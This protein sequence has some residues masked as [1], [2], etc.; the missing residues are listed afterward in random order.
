MNLKK[1][2][3]YPQL[4]SSS[5]FI[6]K[7]AISSHFFNE[8]LINGEDLRLV[9]EILLEKQ[10]Y[11]LLNTTEY[12]YR[13][14]QDSSSFMDNRLSSK[15]AYTEKMELCFKHLIDYSIRKYSYVP[16]FIQYVIALD[17]NG[18]ISST[19]FEDVI[20]D[21]DELFEFWDCLNYIM[22]YI[23]EDVIKNHD[24]LTSEYKKFYMYLKNKKETSIN[25]SSKKRVFLKS[26]DFVIDR[27]HRDKLFLDIIEIKNGF[28]NISGYFSSKFNLDYVNIEAI[29][30]TPNKQ[31]KI[32]PCKKVQYPTTQSKIKKYLG[33]EWKYF[34]NFD[35]KIPIDEFENFKV[36]FRYIFKKE[37][38]EV[39]IKPKL[40]FRIYANLSLVSNYFVKDSKIV[41]FKDNALH[42]VD[43]SSKFRIKLELSSLL[44]IIKSNEENKFEGIFFRLLYYI[45]YNHY[46]S[47]RIWL[48]M[49]RPTSAED[50]ARALFEYAV[51]QDEDIEKYFIVDKKSK[52]YK[53]LKKLSKHVVKYRSIK[54]KLLY[55]FSEKIISSHVDA[56]WLN[57]YFD[58]NRRLFSGLSTIEACFLQHGVTKDDIS[59][60]IR[61]YFN[62]L[63]LF[64]TT[65]DYERDSIL[66]GNDATFMGSM[67]Y[68][69][70]SVN[71]TSNFTRFGGGEYSCDVVCYGDG[72]FNG[73]TVSGDFTVSGK[74]SFGGSR[75]YGNLTCEGDANLQWVTV[76]KQ[77]VLKGDSIRGT[78]NFNKIINY[79][80]L[81]LGN[82]SSDESF[83]LINNG[84]TVNFYSGVNDYPLNNCSFINNN[85]LFNILPTS[86]G[87]YRTTFNNCSLVN[88]NGIF[89]F[90]YVNMHDVN[91]TNNGTFISKGSPYVTGSNYINNGEME[92]SWLSISGS[93]FTNNGNISL[94][95]YVN[96]VNLT[97]NG[98]FSI[99]KGKEN[100]Y[101]SLYSCNFTNTG[102]FEI[103]KYMAECDIVNEGRI[104]SYDLY[105]QDNEMKNTGTFEFNNFTNIYT[106]GLNN[107]NGK[108]IFTNIT[109]IE[110][111]DVNGGE[112]I[113]KG[114][115]NV[116]NSNLT[117][118]EIFN[119]GELSIQ[120]CSAKGVDVFNDG[121]NV[122]TNNENISSAISEI[123]SIAAS[124]F[125]TVYGSGDA[126]K[127]TFT[128]SKG[129]ALSNVEVS[130]KVNGKEFK[131]TT[132]SNGV[133]SFIP[134]LPAGKY[135]VEVI[136]LAT[137]KTKTFTI[138]VN[139][140]TTKLTV[141]K[142]VEYYGNKK[143]LTINVKDQFGKNVNG[144]KLAIKIKG[145]TYYTNVNN[146]VAKL[147]T[148]LLNVGTYSV[149]LTCND[150]NY[151]ISPLKTII[152][153]YKAKTTVK[154]PK[155]TFKYKKSK[156]FTITIKS[157]VTKKA[158]SKI[159]IKVKVYTGKKYKVYKLK[160]NKKGVA[161]LN[162]KKLKKGKHKVV[163]TSLNKNYKI[164]KKSLIRIK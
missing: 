140:A 138:T 23:D 91:L 162:T 75:V 109:Y 1:E 127:A 53:D 24:Y 42:V 57:P 107:E 155:K 70:K 106:T 117:S 50:N 148:P 43:Y 48:F 147:K 32:Y 31:K 152:K 60:W 44:N 139:K 112:I 46:N 120:N 12:K 14:R 110:L 61:K 26:K 159:K 100:Y 51:K 10:K 35:L 153:V 33:I 142:I 90:Y 81:I 39:I 86:A 116:K 96:N 160:T 19:F 108:L 37:D 41:L 84:G 71:S 126:Y 52:D 161:K 130:F 123:D 72:E 113:N 137:G 6:K 28:L 83:T 102:Y 9:N 79:K 156:K 25:I 131:S 133:A 141:K 111:L 118:V 74:S 17:L 77:L 114:T 40:A 3:N 7:D 87:Q 73:M 89:D 21:E 38:E 129:N 34:N 145:K 101:T 68:S 15:R 103:M 55:L 36:S 64:V 92:I 135:D 78:G 20:T 29:V 121:G 58:S 149:A 54:H 82:V 115:N 122:T 136:N 93:N 154:A 56:F 18:V 63:F 80:N 105:Y 151:V 49:D 45:F 22:K 104:V 8:N 158:V 146:G 124:D 27:L 164:S 88:N 62:N 11:G 2:Y 134:Q 150:N 97:N 95:F 65:S 16:K 98:N 13:K 30:K 157:K 4:S 47:K 69:A 119:L 163:I 66:N 5:S 76:G 144:I 94:D 99:M 143:T 132:D 125:T 59:F 67:V 85:G 128:D